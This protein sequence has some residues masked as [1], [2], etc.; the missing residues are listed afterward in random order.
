M[1][2]L[3]GQKVGHSMCHKFYQSTKA[4]TVNS[5]SYLKH[6]NRHDSETKNKLLA[7]RKNKLDIF[8]GRTSN[9]KFKYSREIQSRI[10]VVISQYGIF[11]KKQTDL[12]LLHVN[13]Y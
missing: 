6:R 8:F 10:V 11:I 5:V 13:I 7:H 2:T 12:E 4:K 9:N 3:Y 1:D